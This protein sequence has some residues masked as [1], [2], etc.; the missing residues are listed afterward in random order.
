MEIRLNKFI[1]ESGMC[2]RREADRLIAV[3]KVTIN[4]RQAQVGDKVRPGDEVRVSGNLLDYAHDTVYIALNKPVGVVSTTD[5]AEPNNIVKFVNFPMRIFNIGR[6]DKQSEGLI[7]LTNDGDIV[8]K[9]LRAENN[10]DKEYEVVV[11]RPVTEGFIAKMEQGVPI[12][13]TMTKKCKVQQTGTHSFTITLTQGLN[14][15]IRRMCEHLE[16]EVLRLKRT[17]IMN[18]KLDRQL[19][20]GQWRM[21]EDDEVKVLLESIK[22]STGESKVAP[23]NSQ[24]KKSNRRKPIFHNP[25]GNSAGHSEENPNKGGR[26]SSTSG[27]GRRGAARNAKPRRSS[28]T[29]SGSGAG[30]NSGAK[31]FGSPLSAAKKSSA[32]AS[33][34]KPKSANKPKPSKSKY[35]PKKQA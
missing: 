34:G 23:G 3:G 27:A 19:P 30:V 9:I 24:K 7:L 1:S 28:S 25:G 6:L 17:R 2:T 10:H 12:L 18:I 11:N 31:R 22:D 15:Q 5:M 16:Y 33:K 14:R 29:G 4:R 8:N 35:T 20:V 32:A 26:S 21:L 13:G